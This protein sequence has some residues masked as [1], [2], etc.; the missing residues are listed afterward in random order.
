MNSG[1]MVNNGDRSHESG[2]PMKQTAE[3]GTQAER[4]RESEERGG[5]EGIKRSILARGEV[6]T[7]RKRPPREEGGRTGGHGGRGGWGGS[8]IGW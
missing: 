8:K 5:F 6:L 1:L 4:E 3:K 2:E 7:G